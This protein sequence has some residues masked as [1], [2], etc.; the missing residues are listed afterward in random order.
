MR[1]VARQKAQSVMVRDLHEIARAPSGAP[2][3][4]VPASGPAFQLGNRAQVGQR[5]V[6]QH[7]GRQPAPGRDS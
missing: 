1:G 2:I 3:A 5:P 6:A 4:D 7:P